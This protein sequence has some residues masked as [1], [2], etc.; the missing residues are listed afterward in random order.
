MKR[1][2]TGEIA[3]HLRLSR[4]DSRQR[5][6]GDGGGAL[7]AVF[8]PVLRFCGTRNDYHGVTVLVALGAILLFSDTSNLSRSCLTEVD[9]DLAAR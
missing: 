8:G 1:G 2:V 4:P 6:S 5:R 3:A 9:R 7:D